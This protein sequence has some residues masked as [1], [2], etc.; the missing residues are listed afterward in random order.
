M[1]EEQEAAAPVADPSEGAGG[2]GAGEGEGAQNYAGFETP[3]L[4]A[5]GFESLQAEKTALE[6]QVTNLES[7]KGR[8]GNEI[9]Q[10]KDHINR[11]TGQ[12]EGMKTSESA[13]QTPATPTID[14]IAR[15]LDDG[16]I[17]E[18]DA[19]KLVHKA[20]ISEAEAR[21]KGLVTSEIGKLKQE[22][23]NEKYVA[24]YLRDNPG[25]QEAYDSG[26][27]GPWMDQGQ[28]GED[29]WLNFQL[30]A[31]KDEITSLKE[32][33][34]KATE[35]AEEKGLEKG[36]KIEKGKSAAGSVL[37]G[38]TTQ[39]TQSGEKVDLNDRTQRNQAGHAYLQKLRE[40]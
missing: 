11:L 12:I 8:H 40:S 7:L 16:D 26:K 37:S 30:Q 17:T 21:M 25:Y 29:A 3:E 18:A 27:L 22:N 31:S 14:E 35:E 24:A 28:S 34:K 15:Q 19:L 10:L 6:D 33:A 36:I 2:Q 23:A 32:K 38:K 5:T 13:A 1:S 9:G 4:L 39:F 20:G